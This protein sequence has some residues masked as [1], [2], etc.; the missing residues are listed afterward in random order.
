MSELCMGEGGGGVRSRE[1]Q[2]LKAMRICAC[3]ILHWSIDPLPGL[4]VVS[5]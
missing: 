1:V 5:L 4:V 2:R 3:A